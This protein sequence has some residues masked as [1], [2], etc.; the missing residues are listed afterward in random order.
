M[1]DFQQRLNDLTGRLYNLVFAP[2]QSTIDGGHD[3]LIAPDGQLCLLPFEILP[4]PD[5]SFVIENYGVSYLSSGRDLF[6]YDDPPPYSNQALVIADPDFDLSLASVVNQVDRDPFENDLNPGDHSLSR[7]AKACLPVVF[8]RLLYSRREAK[9]ITRSLMEKGN[10]TVT[11]YYG[12]EAL[13]EVLKNLGDSPR[14]L[15][16]ATHGFF[17]EDIDKSRDRLFENPLLRS[18]LALAG[19]NNLNVDS[20]TNRDQVEDGILTA[21]EVSGLN[22]GGTELV[23]VSACEAGV[24]DIRNGEGVFGLRRAMQLAGVRSVLMS[25]WK[26]PDRETRILM[27]NFYNHWLDKV[28]KKTALRRAILK[29]IETCREKYGVAYPYF[30]GGFVLIGDPY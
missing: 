24:G 1:A 28:S 25:L 21:F 5:S 12:P 4:R 6:K 18:G 26:I 3:L 9:L 14:V 11:A 7:G 30:W 13:E 19:A 17:C 22:L 10:L 16:L 15:H 29:V 27:E 8:N 20:N 2:L 23:V